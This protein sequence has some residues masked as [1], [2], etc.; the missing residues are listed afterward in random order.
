MPPYSNYSSEEL[1]LA[2]YDSGNLPKQCG[3]SAGAPEGFL[4]GGLEGTEVET[5][6]SSRGIVSSELIGCS[7][8][9]RTGSESTSTVVLLPESSDTRSETNVVRPQPAKRLK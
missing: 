8:S 2:D 6:A 7:T 5:F 3:N 1:R 4:G 9:S